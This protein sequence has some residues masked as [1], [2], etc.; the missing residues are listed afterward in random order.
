GVFF[1]DVAAVTD[2]ERVVLTVATVLGVHETPEEPIEDT[3]DRHLAGRHLLLVLDNCE[4]L[5]GVCAALSER[6]LLA[7]PGLKI[8]VTS[9]EGLGVP[10]ESLLPVRSLSVPPAGASDARAMLASEAVR[11]FIDRARLVDP[12]FALDD[13]NASATGEICRRLDGIPLA[14]ELAAAR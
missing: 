3:L 5:L 4:H 12:K 9:R 14:L 7:A 8:L 6:W 1:A 10:G 11:L 2:A 13:A